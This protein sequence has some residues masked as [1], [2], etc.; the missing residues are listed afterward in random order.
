[1]TRLGELATAHP[2]IT[3]YPNHMAIDLIS[4]NKTRRVQKRLDRCLGAYVLDMDTF[5]VKTVAAKAVVVATGGLGKVFIFTTNPDTASGDG[6]AMCY[7]MGLPLVNMEFI[8]FHPTVYYDPKASEE[9]ERRVLFT[10]ALRGAG[11]FLKLY[12]DDTDDF[13]LRYD[14]RGSKASRDVVTRAED[15]EMKE[16]GLDF[17][18]L[19][20]ST[21]G[22]DELKTGFQTF[23]NFCIEKGIDPTQEPVPVIYAAHYSNGGVLVSLCGETL[24]AD[25]S[26]LE[27]LYV[28][29]ETAYTGLHGATRLASNSGPEAIAISLSAATRFL[30]N[31]NGIVDTRSVPSWD[32]GSATVSGERERLGEYWDGMRRTMTRKCGVARDAENL[33]EALAAM[34]R[35]GSRLNRYY[36]RYFLERDMLENRNIQE[37]SKLILRSALFRKETRACHFRTDHPK[38]RPEYKAWTVLKR[39]EQPRLVSI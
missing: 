8:Q 37:V 35:Y 5:E 19:D 6:F 15:I 3:V 26:G 34:T 22:E 23:Y 7:R 18:W 11:A 36:W 21:I 20:C 30:E 12:R 31:C 33:R 24:Y 14:P 10:E 39:G 16:R 1:M 2:N 32:V 27:N 29:G 25:G 13:V 17:V 4:E 9:S 38:S 28:V